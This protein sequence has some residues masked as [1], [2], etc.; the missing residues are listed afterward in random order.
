MKKDIEIHDVIEMAK[1]KL[2]TSFVRASVGKPFFAVTCPIP[3][4]Q[5]GPCRIYVPDEFSA[6]YAT[7]LTHS[8]WKI[9][10][11]GPTFISALDHVGILV[12]F[13]NAVVASRDRDARAGAPLPPEKETKT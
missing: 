12:N 6:K 7:E 5:L 11:H 10:A 13:V 3:E 9:I 8:M 2:G 4:D 1:H